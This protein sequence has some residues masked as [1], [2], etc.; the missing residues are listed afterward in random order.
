LLNA[1]SLLEWFGRL[2]GFA[3]RAVPAAAAALA[4]PSSWARPLYAVLIGGLPLA[5]VAGLALG[6]VIWLHTRDVLARTGTGAVE[7][8]PTFL[9]AAVLLELAPVGAGLI[10]AARTGASLGAELASMR[11]GEQIDALELL[12]ESPMRRLV[13]PRVVVC[14]LAAPLLH[15]LIAAVALGSGF[16]A[17]GLTGSTTYLKYA[18]AALRELSLEDVVPAGLKTLAF[19]LVVGVTGCFVGLRPREGAEGVGR[20][21]TD[22]VVACVLLVLAA[23]VLLVVLIKAAQRAAGV[24]H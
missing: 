7:Y 11:V 1:I 19:G 24:G 23:D 3:A 2:T 20:A 13:G 18:T 9:A 17:E 16:A 22:G 6:V 10:V 5:A 21:A 8:L 4:R 14:V 12:G 15:V